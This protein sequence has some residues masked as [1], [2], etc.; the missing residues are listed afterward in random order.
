M[1]HAATAKSVI[2]PSPLRQR[3]SI[4]PTLRRTAVN[5]PTI[6][7]G[8][9]VMSGLGPTPDI[10]RA[11]GPTQEGIRMEAAGPTQQSVPRV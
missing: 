3:L 10:Q 4:A 6:G 2:K 11:L 7:D 5:G 9:F 1:G 8:T